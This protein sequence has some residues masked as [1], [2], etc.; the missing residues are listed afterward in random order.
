MKGK[1]ILTIIFASFFTVLLSSNK[2]SAA[3]PDIHNNVIT[4]ATN[5]YS[6]KINKVT[7]QYKFKNGNGETN[8]SITTHFERTTKKGKVTIKKIDLKCTSKGNSS[9]YI[10]HMYIENRSGKAVSLIEELSTPLI[11]KSLTKTF[12]VNVKDAQNVMVMV[13]KDLLGSSLGK[14]SRFQYNTM[15]Y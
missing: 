7:N 6:S 13:H 3:T 5:I 9:P 8:V 11:N 4:N 10:S 2:V 1:L 12:K 15:F 14:G